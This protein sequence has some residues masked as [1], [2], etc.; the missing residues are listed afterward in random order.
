M[1]IYSKNFVSSTKVGQF[2][3][4]IRKISINIATIIIKLNQIIKYGGEDVIK[5]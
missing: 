3:F 1:E 2:F 4:Q 5:N